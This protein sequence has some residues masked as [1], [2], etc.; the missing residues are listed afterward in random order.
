MFNALEYFRSIKV[1]KIKKVIFMKYLYHIL[2]LCFL[3]L[4]ASYNHVLAS[5]G[6]DSDDDLSDF[7]PQSYPP[8]KRSTLSTS[9]ETKAPKI[10]RH[11]DTTF[12]IQS[13][14]DLLSAIEETQVNEGGTSDITLSLPNSPVVLEETT[15]S[16]STEISQ[17]I[18]YEISFSS[19]NSPI[20]PKETIR[21]IDPTS[22][23]EA[24]KTGELLEN[25]QFINSSTLI[26]TI[27]I[28][29]NETSAT[30]TRSLYT[31]RSLCNSIFDFFRQCCC[32]R[33]HSYSE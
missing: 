22:T 31:R 13:Q 10:L 15:R 33:S 12:Y 6:S 25:Q 24:V 17:N 19:Q 30:N 20:V 28:E 21:S 18:T 16:T 3:I 5:F 2:L 9:P 11:S 7:G 29:N 1:L 23:S 4:N 14:G 26:P 27:Y 32:V 8:P